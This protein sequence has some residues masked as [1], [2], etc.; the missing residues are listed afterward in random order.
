MA[1]IP[2]DLL[3]FYQ[4][5]LGP[6]QKLAL[7]GASVATPKLLPGK[8]LVQFTGLGA[9][10]AWLRAGP[11]GPTPVVAV[12]DVPSTPFVAASP[13]IEIDV[14]RGHNDQF[15]AIMSAGTG[16]MFLTPRSRV[17]KAG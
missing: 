13:P 14:R 10:T 9:N 16:T 15:A 4:N 2:D 7:A 11:H 5:D 6:A 3:D 8:Y 17:P 1:A 12:A